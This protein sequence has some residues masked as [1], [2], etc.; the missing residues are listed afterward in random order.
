MEARKMATSVGEDLRKIL[1]ALDRHP[2]S[3]D[4]EVVISIK[5]HGEQS[6][7]FNITWEGK[8][9]RCSAF[10]RTLKTA[11]LGATNA[12][13]DHINDP[14]VYGKEKTNEKL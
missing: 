3:G 6:Y 14:D 13:L 8:S 12:V 5:Q 1:F 2:T 9:I 4:P 10:D 7:E 11:L